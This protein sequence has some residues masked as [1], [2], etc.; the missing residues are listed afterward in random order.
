MIDLTTLASLAGVALVAGFVDSIAGGGG[1]L[2]LPSL[3]LAG[4]D[5]VSAL[6]TNKLQG[7]FGTASATHTF[8]KRGLL[9]PAQHKYAVFMVFIGAALGVLAVHYAPTRL[10]SGALP[11]LLILIALY[12]AFSPRLSDEASHPRLKPQWFTFGFAPVIGFYDGIFGPGTGSF[13][14]LALVTLFGL[15]MVE[16]TGRTKL[17]NFTSNAASLILFA[18]GG[19][20]IWIIGLVM[21]V[22]QLIGAQ[23][24]ARM[25]IRNGTK[26]IRPL[27]VVVCIAMAAKLLADPNN[28][29]RQ[30]LRL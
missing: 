26:L 23:I 24:G 18:L 21:G 6:A 9:H 16:A 28:P 17:F 4:L 30:L 15:G 13:F 27:L 1:L 10:L 3:L 19:K 7:T 12:F 11:P 2:A 5:P 20:I 25:A 14:M 22:G 8:W 29:V